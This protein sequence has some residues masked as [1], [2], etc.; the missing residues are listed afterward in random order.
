MTNS[1]PKAVPSLTSTVNGRRCQSADGSTKFPDLGLSVFEPHAHVAVKP[2]GE[3]R[4]SIGPDQLG[5]ATG[6][7]V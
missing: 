2:F 5:G 3:H 4:K 1:Q 7:I 6:V